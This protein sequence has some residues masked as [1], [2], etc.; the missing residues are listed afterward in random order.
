MNEAGKNPT[1]WNTYSMI[2][3]EGYLR[4]YCMSLFVAFPQEKKE[5]TIPN[6]KIT[7]NKQTTNTN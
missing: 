5:K 1:Q 3:I 4:V 2:N 6:F 7:Q